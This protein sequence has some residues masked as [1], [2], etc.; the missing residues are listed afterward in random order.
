VWRSIACGHYVTLTCFTVK[1]LLWIVLFDTES[2]TTFQCWSVLL[3][4]TFLHFYLLPC[5]RDWSSLH[6]RMQCKIQIGTIPNLKLWIRKT[7]LLRPL[8]A[9]TARCQAPIPFWS[10][11]CEGLLHRSDLQACHDS[12]QHSTVQLCEESVSLNLNSL[13]FQLV[14]WNIPTSNYIHWAKSSWEAD[15]RSARQEV[16]ALNPSQNPILSQIS[17]FHS[18]TPCL[19]LQDPL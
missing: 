4:T 11:D 2:P 5:S 14:S 7:S 8:Y 1:L 18:H 13:V 19:F 9:L 10:R 16:S 17:P 15:S 12:Q 6:W 3:C